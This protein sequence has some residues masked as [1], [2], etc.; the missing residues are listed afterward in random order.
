MK[1]IS[2]GKSK[3]KEAGKQ[4]NQIVDTSAK[5]A[6]GGQADGLYQHVAEARDHW[7][8]KFALK[9][10]VTVRVIP[11]EAAHENEPRLAVPSCHGRRCN[12]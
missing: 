3:P 9:P 2:A 1:A 6:K 8:K 5:I 11:I 4:G 10:V 12:G 7:A